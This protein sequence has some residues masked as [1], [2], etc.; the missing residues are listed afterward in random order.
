MFGGRYVDDAS[1]A[2]ERRGNTHKKE[3]NENTACGNSVNSDKIHASREQNKIRKELLWEKKNERSIW[4]ML[5][6][7]V[8]KY[9]PSV[10]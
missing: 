6:N 1:Q 3:G 10:P 9:T 5:G 2:N 8:L 4:E 7:R